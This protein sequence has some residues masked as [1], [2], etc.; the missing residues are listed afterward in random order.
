MNERAK[1]AYLYRDSIQPKI[2]DGTLDAY[3]V[4]YTKDTHENYVISPDLQPWSVR[5]RIYVFNSEDEANT[6]LNINSDTYVGQIVSIIKGEVCKG[7]IVNKNQ[8][9]NYYVKQISPDDIDY[10]NLGNRPIENLIGTLDDPIVINTLL[11]G[12]YKIKGQYK[13]LDN[14]VTTYLSTNGDLFLIEI[15]NTD[16]YIKRFTRDNIYDYKITDTDVVKN[17][18]ITD[19]YLVNNKYTTEN[20]VDAKIAAFE[21]TIKADIENHVAQAVE[22]AI[23]NRVDTIIDERLDV[24]LDAKIQGSTDEEVQD[25]FK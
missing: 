23:I 16:K 22:N 20:Y 18:Y 6:Q 19:E 9:D 4:V 11:P 21:E 14:E 13:I 12:T 25:F 24:K 8:D 10:N 7:Y 1:W 5:S 15:K 17:V 3:D 2:D